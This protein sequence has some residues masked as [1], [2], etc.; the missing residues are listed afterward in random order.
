[1]STSTTTAA[2]PG[3]REKLLSEFLAELRAA[4]PGAPIPYLRK[5]ALADVRR[6][7]LTDEGWRVITR[8]IW[9]AGLRALL[10]ETASDEKKPPRMPDAGP[11]REAQRARQQDDMERRL[12][13]VIEDRAMRLLDH[14]TLAGG[15][16]LGDCT[17]ADCR[18][19]AIREPLFYGELA[20]RLRPSEHVRNHLSEAELQAIYRSCRLA[21]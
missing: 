6:H 20:K 5:L 3:R 11:E 2:Q 10:T 1:M 13:A 21:V 7:N 18:K 19:L 16:L 17:G 14:P 8:D 9:V 15:K 12:D 4:N